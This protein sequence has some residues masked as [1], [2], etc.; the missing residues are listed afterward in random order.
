L[1]LLITP[2]LEARHLKVPLPGGGTLADINIAL[3][4]GDFLGIVGPPG[5]GKSHLLKTLA[6]LTR[7]AQGEVWIDTQP[8]TDVARV[9]QKLGYCGGG[10]ELFPEMTV[11]E[12]LYFF[13]EA[14]G[15]DAPYVPAGVQH[16]LALTRLTAVADDPMAQLPRTA[17]RR[18]GLARALVHGPRVLLLD[19]PLRKFEGSERDLWVEILERVRNQGAC[20]AMAAE[21]VRDVRQLL[22]HA[23]VLAAGQVLGCGPIHSLDSRLSQLRSIQLQVMGASRAISLLQAWPGVFQA[24]GGGDIVKVLFMGDT[25]EVLNLVRFLSSQGLSVV[26]FRQ[27]PA[28][29]M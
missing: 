14:S 23:C 19:D 1:K 29:L 13:A 15:V 17:L 6:T 27:E 16:A 24:S 10:P 11:R 18:A 8:A 25:A 5:V 26:S 2:L 22:T 7:P 12:F 9:R 4:P 21:T 28:Y 3:Y 20:I